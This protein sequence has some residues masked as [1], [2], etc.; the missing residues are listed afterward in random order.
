MLFLV[1][2]GADIHAQGGRYGNALQAAAFGGKDQTIRVMIERGA[3]VTPSGGKYGSALQAA[4]YKGRRMTAKLLIDAGADTNVESFYV[5]RLSR[6]LSIYVDKVRRLIEEGSGV[7]ATGG[8]CG[9]ALNAACSNDFPSLLVLLRENLKVDS[10]ESNEHKC[11]DDDDNEDSRDVNQ[12]DG[13]GISDDE[14]MP[15]NE[16]PSVDDDQKLATITE[17]PPEDHLAVVKLLIQHGA[18]IDKIAGRYGTSLQAATAAGNKDVVDVLLH[19][20]ARVDTEDGRYWTALQAAA[21]YGHYAVVER[22]V[23]A[24]ARVNV[25]W[26]SYRCSSCCLCIWS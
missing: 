16:G 25:R 22:L 1:K 3:S 24:G 14:D 19:H 17:L 18:K 7:N 26:P 15:D 13:E 11:G 4:A 12:S 21:Q 20:G 8:E 6:T 5:E 10:E 23:Q 9:N 2:N